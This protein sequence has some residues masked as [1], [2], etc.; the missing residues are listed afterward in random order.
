MR[1][2]PFYV[3]NTPSK[4]CSAAAGPSSISPRCGGRRGSCESAYSASK[5]A[6]IAFTKALARE[7]APAGIT[8]NCVTPGVIDTAMNG[9]LSEEEKRA[10]AEEIPLGRFGTPEEV[11]R[12]VLFLLD[13]PYVTG[14]VL[15]VNGGF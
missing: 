8:V 10:L 2:G 1:A 9:H 15:G 6:V 11:A 3:A 7:L 12:A 13:N 4:R 5:G 14:Q